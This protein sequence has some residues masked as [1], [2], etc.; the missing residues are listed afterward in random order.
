MTLGLYLPLKLTEQ[1][2]NF[3]NS[4]GNVNVDY[5]TTDSGDF[6]V[7]GTS[8]T[9][10]NSPATI[11][12]NCFPLRVSGSHI[13]GHDN[14]FK[15]FPIDVVLENM[16]GEQ[17][18]YF[19]TTTDS[20]IVDIR[21]SHTE[22]QRL[23]GVSYM[24][25]YYT[26]VDTSITETTFVGKTL[27]PCIFNE[28]KVTVGLVNNRDML[29]LSYR[30]VP[31]S[32]SSGL[33]KLTEQVE[34]IVTNN[35]NVST[36]KVNPEFLGAQSL[37]VAD[38]TKTVTSS[39]FIS[40]INEDETVNGSPVLTSRLPNYNVYYTDTNTN[41]TTPDAF[42]FP[43]K[44]GE[45]ALF[46]TTVKDTSSDYIGQ[47]SNTTLSYTERFFPGLGKSF[48]CIRIQLPEDPYLDEDGNAK[49]MKFSM[50]DG[51]DW[52]YFKNY[53]KSAEDVFKVEFAYY[54]KGYGIKCYPCEDS[55]YI[56]QNYSDKDPKFAFQYHP[57][58]HIESVTDMPDII[59][60]DGSEFL[61]TPQAFPEN[62][63][64]CRVSLYG[65]E[66]PP[67]DVDPEFAEYAFRVPPKKDGES[68]STLFK[69]TITLTV[70]I[71]VLITAI[72]FLYLEGASSITAQALDF[73][74]ETSTTVLDTFVEIL[75]TIMVNY[76]FTRSGSEIVV[77]NKTN[78]WADFGLQCDGV[79]VKNPELYLKETLGAL[80]TILLRGS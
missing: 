77:K 68:I 66:G 79:S 29:A 80:T 24:Y 17:R 78:T 11:S 37:V 44:A 27:K 13:S 45:K 61:F 51:T 69:D 35:L 5:R 73:T 12:L 70:D 26:F 58:F 4:S 31:T 76:I 38:P 39:K 20:I 42:A 43:L 19:Y 30:D 53:S 55:T 25:H 65:S 52:M 71:D 33:L 32:F 40:I 67:E 54:L 16:S 1:I 47:L 2:D 36:S 9:R 7:L 41:S 46:S 50:N 8:Y 10:V 57:D 15:E 21:Y 75:G 14:L 3:K 62:Y 49:Q 59:T 6:N 23:G 18:H 63:S 60:E 48:A 72:R 34:E 22:S 64:P 28:Q 56:L 74:A